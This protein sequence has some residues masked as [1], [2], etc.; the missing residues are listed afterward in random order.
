MF[1]NSRLYKNSLEFKAAMV[2]RCEY[3]Q[4]DKANYESASISQTSFAVLKLSSKATE[5]QRQT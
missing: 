5:A 4:I 1:Q 2:K 3:Q